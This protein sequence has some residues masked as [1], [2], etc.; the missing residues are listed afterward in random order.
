M[1]FDPESLRDEIRT[2]AEKMQGNYDKI[3]A[4]SEEV[5]GSDS[6]GS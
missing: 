3:I 6:K 4:I 1:V 5:F 2:E